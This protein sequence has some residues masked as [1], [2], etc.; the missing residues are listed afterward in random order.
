M[1]STQYGSDGGLWIQDPLR[2]FL[3]Y[4]TVMDIVLCHHYLAK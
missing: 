1:G 3:Q 2:N 4:S